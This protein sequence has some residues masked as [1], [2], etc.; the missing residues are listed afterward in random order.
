METSVHRSDAL[1][2]ALVSIFSAPGF[3][4]ACANCFAASNRG[5]LR[6]YYISTTILT[7]MPFILIAGIMFVAY[8]SGQRLPS[9]GGAL[10]RRP[11]YSGRINSK[12]SL[13]KRPS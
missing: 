9:R 4:S 3:A 5:G 7:L 10:I 6:A 8:K 2:I 12:V 1:W 11:S 13:T